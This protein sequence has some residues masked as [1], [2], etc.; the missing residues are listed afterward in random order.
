[1]KEIV[2][3]I[4]AEKVEVIDEYMCMLLR[5]VKEEAK[6]SE[7]EYGRLLTHIECGEVSDVCEV[8]EESLSSYVLRISSSHSHDY[9]SIYQIIYPISDKSPSVPG[10]VENEEDFVS[11][12]IYSAATINITDIGIQ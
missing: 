8:L 10:S 2:G 12:R 3:E 1:M 9:T 4:E 5:Q 6:L 11:S 7:V